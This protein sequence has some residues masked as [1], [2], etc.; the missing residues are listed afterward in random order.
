MSPNAAT[1]PAGPLAVLSE[2][3]SR[4]AEGGAIVGT[5]GDVIQ[6]LHRALDATEVSLW[7]YASNGLQRSAIAGAAFLTADDAQSAAEA[8]TLPGVVARR[9]VSKGQ[10][11][12]ILAVGGATSMTAEA[13]EILTIVTNLLAPELVHAEDVH[14]LTGEVARSVT[15]QSR[16]SDD[17]P[18]G[19]STRSRSVS[20]SWTATTACRPGTATG[21]WDCRVCRAKMPSGS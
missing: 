11:I 7:L 18:R 15:G 21:R 17:S 19:S 12:G 1:R 20:T 14:R 3:A 16:R 2:I 5:V 9:L 8:D 13:R 10:R 6:R 4:L